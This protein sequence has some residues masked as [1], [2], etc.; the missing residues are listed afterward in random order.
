[1]FFMKKDKEEE[2]L[3]T[4]NALVSGSVAVGTASMTTEY[5]NEC[6]ALR[7][8]LGTRVSAEQAA[9]NEKL[10]ETPGYVGDRSK[11][12][13]TAYEYEVADVKMGGHG[14]AGWNDT[15]CAELLNTGKVRGAEG[16]HTNNVADHPEMQTNPDNITFYRD[17]KSHLERG[18]NGDFRNA[19]SGPLV[20]KDAMLERTNTKRVLKN[21]ACGALFATG[22]GMVIGLG[23]SVY[24]S[25]K[26]EGLSFKSIGK[27]IKKSGTP[28]MKS[29]LCSVSSYALTR[30]FSYIFDR[31]LK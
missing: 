7:E 26:E 18:H 30:S 31:F 1:M 5:N 29:A 11:G 24:D 27:G 14:S 3:Q 9:L 15:E 13:S 10:K 12:V 4:A 17:R 28:V 25:C 21:E 16:H 22:T 6:N 2:K 23:S 8:T 20:N 19:S